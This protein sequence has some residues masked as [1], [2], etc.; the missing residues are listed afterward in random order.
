MGRA[1]RAGRAAS[2][3]GGNGRNNGRDS[4]LNGISSIR[5]STFLSALSGEIR[6]VRS[7][8]KTKLNLLASG[9]RL[10]EDV[11]YRDLNVEDVS[12]DAGLAKG[13][14]YIH[15]PSK[16]AFLHEMARRYVD[17]ER[18]IYPVLPSNHSH[19]ANVRQWIAWYETTFMNNVGVLRAMVQMADVDAT[20]CAIWHDRNE[21]IADRTLEFA[22]RRMG[23]PPKDRDLFHLMQRTAGGMLDQSLF[24]RLRI[25]AGP[26]IKQE[27][28]AEFLIELHALMLYRALYGQNPPAD[29]AGEICA[30][31]EMQV[32]E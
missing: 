25:Q 1:G 10:L 9:V 15:F 13:T 18:Q 23:Q 5:F 31:V 24:A 4:G 11:G 21:A 14:F 28:P 16:D 27:Y 2:N 7:G 22:V 30:L 29:Q 8:E 20:M 3:G 12:L 26:G 17:Y 32:P 19:Y 6:K